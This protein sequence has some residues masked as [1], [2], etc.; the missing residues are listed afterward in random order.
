MVYRLYAAPFVSC[1]VHTLRLAGMTFNNICRFKKKV[2]YENGSENMGG[3]NMHR[4][5]VVFLVGFEA[6]FWNFVI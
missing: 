2:K 6:K 4:R 1:F 3:I 5:S